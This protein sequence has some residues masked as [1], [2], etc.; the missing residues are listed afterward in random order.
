MLNNSYYEI[1]NIDALK[2]Q[3]SSIMIIGLQGYISV[4]IAKNLLKNNISKLY[5]YD[6]NVDNY[7]DINKI[8][9]ILIKDLYNKS[10]QIEICKDYININTDI[11]III[12][13][14]IEFIIKVN[15]YSRKII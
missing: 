4:E 13:Q 12:N 3:T 6:S 15:T 5:L 7:N 2:I 14:S 11:I 8:K 9:S 10:S 1:K